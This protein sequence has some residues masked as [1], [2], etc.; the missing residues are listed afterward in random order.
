[1]EIV[2]EI[3]WDDEGDPVMVLSKRGQVKTAYIIDK[4]PTR[5]FAIRLNDAWM[6]SEEHNPNFIQTMYG[7]CRFLCELW[8][9]GLPTTRRMAELAT[10]IQSALDDLLAAKPKPEITE[11]IG[12]VKITVSGPNDDGSQTFVNDLV[13][14]RL[15][16]DKDL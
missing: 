14:S 4:Y 1:M 10:I 6:F 3:K 2:R 8:D 9:L 12:E 13:V 11:T 15:V 16:D 7:V 5:T